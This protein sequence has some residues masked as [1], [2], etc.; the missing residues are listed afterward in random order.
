MII[1]INAKVNFMLQTVTAGGGAATNQQQQQQRQANGIGGV[2]NDSA[3]GHNG[4]P[5]VPTSSSS[6]VGGLGALAGLN[7]GLGGPQPTGYEAK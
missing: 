1:E 7:N 6:G 2:V 4:Y 5:G 3:S